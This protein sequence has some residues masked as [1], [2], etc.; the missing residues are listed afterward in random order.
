[1]LILVTDWPRVL[2]PTG[3]W[4]RLE[5]PIAAV[6]LKA[7]AKLNG[8]A[9]TQVGGTVYWDRAGIHTWSPPDDRHLTSQ[10]VWEALAGS[11]GDLPS[12]V[13]DALKVARETRDEE[14]AQSIRDHY[15]RNVYA[16]TRAVFEE[17][18][19]RDA[20]ITVE[21]ERVEGQVATTLVM[22]E[23]KKPHSKN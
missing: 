13:R 14:Q 20:A 17:I 7:G 9:F 19:A 1:M 3:E 15:L 6:G 11:D 18:N 2:P 4:V 12:R 22:K 10:R 5:V 8:W 23:R 21:E 16:P